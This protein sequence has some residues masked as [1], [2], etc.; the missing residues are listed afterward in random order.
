MK[1]FS[2]FSHEREVLECDKVKIDSILNREITIT[3][4]SIKKSR[5]G[6]NNSGKYLTLQYED[7]NGEK[8]VLFTGSDV[9]I[10][11]MEKYANEIPFIT[12]IKKIDRYYTL[13]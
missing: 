10:E 4:Y 13:T 12:I 5:Y 9:L 7:D 1:R 3:G 8:K 11:Q 2:D 6:N